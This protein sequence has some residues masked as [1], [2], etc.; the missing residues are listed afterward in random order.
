[1]GKTVHL[2]R[3]IF[4]PEVLPKKDKIS[5]TLFTSA[6]TGYAPSLL[7]NHGAGRGARLELLDD[8]DAWC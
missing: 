2:L 8:R 1:M 5:N 6:S 7:A 3:L 4:S